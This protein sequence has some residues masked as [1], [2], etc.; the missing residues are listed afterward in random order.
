M[1]TC[2]ERKCKFWNGVKCTDQDEYV[3][4]QGDLVCRYQDGAMLYDEYIEEKEN[5]QEF[6]FGSLPNEF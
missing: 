1:N 4:N 6:D 5:N 3:N 2:E